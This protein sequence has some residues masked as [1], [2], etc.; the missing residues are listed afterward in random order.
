MANIYRMVS[1]VDYQKR[2]AKKNNISLSEWG[3]IATCN[4]CGY[5]FELYNYDT[6]QLKKEWWKCPYMCNSGEKVELV[7]ETNTKD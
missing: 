1:V 5:R 4:K 3:I 2:I 7:P 6:N